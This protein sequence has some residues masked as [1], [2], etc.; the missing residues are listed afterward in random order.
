MLLEWLDSASSLHL[1]GS[2]TA[3]S[4]GAIF[5]GVSCFAVLRKE[6]EMAT[7]S[8]VLSQLML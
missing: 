8:F 2:I 6:E 4:S 3:V 7:H 5:L 1:L